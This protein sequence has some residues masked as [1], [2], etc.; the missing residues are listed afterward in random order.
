M[1]IIF[2]LPV[3]TLKIREALYMNGGNK[4]VT[5]PDGRLIPQLGQGTWR[6]GENA[7]K[8]RA[9][10]ESLRAGIKMGMTLIDTAEMYGSGGAEEITGEA[11]KDFDREDLFLVSK[12]YP[13]NAG[14]ANIFKSCEN[15]LKR[16]SVDRLDLYLLH[17]RGSVPLRETVECM[18]KLVRDGLINGW[19]VSNFDL[20][21]M[22]ELWS[23]PGGD[24]CQVNQVLYHLGSRGIEFD[25]LPWMNDKKIPVMAY[26]PLAQAGRL[27][28]GI[29]QNKLLMEVCRRRNAQPGQI[30]LAFVLQM[31]MIAIP[32]A[33]SPAH[34]L[35][36]A[37]SLE[38]KLTGDD[39]AL[40]S[41][42]YPAPAG[43]M[44][45]DMS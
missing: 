28:N 21:D 31:N 9:E 45:L 26:S 11:I 14:R 7:A 15:S 30:L 19:G 40:L 25:L 39:I 36:N 37:A 38:I 4:K 24:D 27:K 41:E 33:G 10:T 6:M 3:N 34:I 42:A 44:P 8:R 13:Y 1:M 29:M 32:K 18:Q 2:G 22:Q 20:Q 43:K 17:W 5:L 16:L 23:V 35:E 12:V